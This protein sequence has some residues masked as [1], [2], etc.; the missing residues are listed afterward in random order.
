MQQ[1]RLV[2]E[3]DGGRAALIVAFLGLLWVA[4]H[5]SGALGEQSDITFT[6]LAVT[7]VAA[8]VVGVRKWRPDPAWPWLVV[9]AALLLFLVS[10]FLRV[11]LETL[12]DLTA[13]RSLLPDLIALP[14]YVVLGAGVLALVH[15]R[16]RGHER[17]LDAVLDATLAALAALALAWVYLIGPALAQEHV[18]LAVRLL[19]VCYPP[20]SVFLLAI[21]TRMS[22]SPDTQESLSFWL[23]LS[24]IGSMLVGDVIYMLVDIHLID[25][26]PELIDV[27][28][29]LAYV[30]FAAAMLHPSMRRITQP[31]ATPTT[32]RARLSFV[33]VALSVP[34]LV[35]LTRTDSDA[36]GRIVLAVIV[37]ALTAAAAW[38][39]LRA[40]RQH[41]RSEAE[42]AHRVT[43]DTLTD[44]ANRSGLQAQ[45][46]ATLADPERAEGTAL[47]LLDIDRFKLVNDS[48]GH[49][50]GDE[51]LVAVAQRLEATTRRNDMVGRV[52]GDEFVVIA[53]EVEDSSTAVEIAE[54][55]RLALGT[56]FRIKGAE[57]PVSASV[58]VV[59]YAPSDQGHLDPVSAAEAMFRDADTAMY[60]AKDAGSDRVALFDA[61]MREAVAVRLAYEGELRHALEREQLHVHYQ[62]IVQVHDGRVTGLE[63]LLRWE[64]PTLGSISPERFIPIAEDTGLICQIGAWVIDQACAQIRQLRDEVPFGDDLWVAVNLSAR[65][66]G[67]ETLL[68]HVA[69]ALVRHH[70]PPD[71]LCLELTESVVM[72]NVAVTTGLLTSI[73]DCGV[74]IAV[75]DFG[76]GYSSLAYLQRLPV[77]KVKIDQSFVR[78]L[79]NDSADGSLVAAVVAIARS[80]GISTV[81]EGVETNGHSRRLH[82]LGCDEAQGYLF[83]R[84]VP[85]E[86]LMATLE[87]LGL[88]AAPRMTV[89][90]GELVE[91]VEPAKSAGDDGSL[92][93]G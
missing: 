8:T 10:G 3:H 22:F 30:C 69:R 37:L 21:G 53:T 62:P 83:S 11:Q 65:Q 16:N 44:L 33:A 2:A 73:R 89:L 84:P 7:A 39:M 18:P 38:R 54:R 1:G 68:D 4:L 34:A 42:L 66:L 64:H 55:T 20:L 50:I 74:R 76:T 60:R 25:L 40:L 15:A 86:N 81:A 23:I 63:A 61:S 41:A 9:L 32:A 56:P 13:D 45:L 43:H 59:V 70:L 85:A 88:A 67:D 12:G 52:G 26:P 29:A 47:L 91:T 36:A 80:L 87:Q 79:T 90:E 46:A 5:A 72:E 58:G 93:I 82:E 19:L 6:L 14:G 57:I 77:D 75:D 31:A 17:D 48:M 49:G 78:A 24:A 92:A 71:S 51:L 35:T 28:Y 27:P